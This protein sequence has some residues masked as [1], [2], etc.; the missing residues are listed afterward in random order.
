M[1]LVG[2][3]H[4]EKLA[5]LFFV[6]VGF[7]DEAALSDGFVEFL[8]LLLLLAHHVFRFLLLH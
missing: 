3:E 5:K 2:A 4:G 8:I 1:R 6:E 7:V